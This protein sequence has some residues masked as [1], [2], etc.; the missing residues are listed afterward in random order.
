MSFQTA[1]IFGGRLKPNHTHIELPESI[2]QNHW[3][4]YEKRNTSHGK[5]EF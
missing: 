4:V 5:N 2:I 3:A 1:F